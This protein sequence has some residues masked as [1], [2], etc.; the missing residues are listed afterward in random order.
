[1]GGGVCRTRSRCS[2]RAGTKEVRIEKT[3]GA[4]VRELAWGP[5]P[6]GI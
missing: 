1:M 5:R 3:G 2:A 6:S 4:G